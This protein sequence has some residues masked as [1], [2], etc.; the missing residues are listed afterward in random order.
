MQV[1]KDVFGLGE[2]G[3]R[4]FTISKSDLYGKLFGA[5]IPAA[6]M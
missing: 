3:G 1:K 4:I 2:I 6:T 5:V